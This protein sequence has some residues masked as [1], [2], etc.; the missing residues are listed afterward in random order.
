MPIR[1]SWTFARQILR[2]PSPRRRGDAA[3]HVRG[4]NHQRQHRTGLPARRVAVAPTVRHQD[5]CDPSGL[6]PDLVWLVAELAVSPFAA[7][8]R[9]LLWPTPRTNRSPPRSRRGSTATCPACGSWPALA[10]VAGGQRALRCSFCSSAWALSTYACIYCGNGGDQF[11][12]AAPD[13]QQGSPDRSPRACGSYLPQDRGRRR[14]LPFPLLSISDIETTDLDLAAM[15]HRYQRPALKEFALRQPRAT[16]GP[17]RFDRS[18]AAFA[19]AGSAACAAVLRCALGAGRPGPSCGTD[20]SSDAAR[21]RK[22][23]PGRQ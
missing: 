13:D 20:R 6:A 3:I 11:V 4:A 15:E 17:R 7:R 16:R 12:T 8:F 5:R 23:N 1:R 22:R 9:T 19:G 18:A 21:F 10:E 2:R 14:A